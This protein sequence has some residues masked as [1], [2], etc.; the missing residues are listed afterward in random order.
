VVAWMVC[1]WYLVK[2]PQNVSGGGKGD[3]E[4]DIVQ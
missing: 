2:G 1:Q 4:D 3:S